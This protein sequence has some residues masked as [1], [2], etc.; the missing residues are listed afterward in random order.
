M[1]KLFNQHYINIVE[2]SSGSKPEKVVCG[3]EGFDKRIFLHNIIKKYEN[4]SNIV[5]IK[6]NMSVKSHLSVSNT[7]ASARQVA[8]NEINL[9]LK[10]FNT[11]EASG[12]NKIPTKLVKLA[13]NFLS[14]PLVTA[15]NNSLA[16]SKFPVVGKVATVIAIDKKD[17]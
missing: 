13:S 11:K 4:H 1:A 9:I 6:N 7:L 14:K 12:T 10:S 8:S 5:K 2:W 3:N 16:S 15:I 17:K